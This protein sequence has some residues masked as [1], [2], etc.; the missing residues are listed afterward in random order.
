M[1]IKGST[2]V[3]K[4]FSQAFRR[5]PRD[6][7]AEAYPQIRTIAIELSGELYRIKYSI[8]DSFIDSRK[9]AKEVYGPFERKEMQKMLVR[10]LLSHIQDIQNRGFRIVCAAEGIAPAEKSDTQAKRRKVHNEAKE[11]WETKAANADVMYVITEE[12]RALIRS[13]YGSLS[14]HDT[15]LVLAALLQAGIP[16]YRDMHSEA[17]KTCAW[18]VR[19]GVADAAWCS[20][21]DTLV[22]GC[23]LTIMPVYSH[24]KQAGGNQQVGPEVDVVELPCFLDALGVDSHDVLINIAIL[25]GCDYNTTFPRLAFLTSHRNM[26]NHDWDV[27]GFIAAMEKKHPD[28]DTALLRYARCRDIFTLPPKQISLLTERV[29]TAVLPK[30]PND[31]SLL[32]LPDS[33]DDIDLLNFVSGSQAAADVDETWC[34][35][36]ASGAFQEIQNIRKTDIVMN[37]IISDMLRKKAQSVTAGNGN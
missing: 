26:R 9:P 29:Q 17:E 25:A 1:T 28:H 10:R 37:A 5:I 33:I 8:F 34:E 22:H 19:N 7:I 23:P 31:G 15:Q 20:D 4:K 6:K 14:S 13:A 27:Q 18:L 21:F 30:N 32:P 24:P 3:K 12:D 11:T 36:H 35:F 2:E 16:V